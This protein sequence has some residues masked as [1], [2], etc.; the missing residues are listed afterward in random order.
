MK[1]RPYVDS[2]WE[3]VREIYDLSKPDEMRGAVDRGAI[4]P[5]NQDPAML[6][7]F[8]T[9]TI[10]VAD[11]AEQI[12][13]FGGNKDNYISWLFVHPAYRRQGVARA[14]LKE[15]IERLDGSITLNVAAEN[16]AARQ[17]YSSLGFVVVR[18]F[19][20]QLNGHAVRV[21]TL[22]YERAG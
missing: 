5:L 11:E 1:I 17:L 2:D 3:V 12:L 13:G 19:A 18:D 15:I 8:R 6:A 4:L 7:L 20:G 22:S 16:R 10:V 14:L 9:S 21:L